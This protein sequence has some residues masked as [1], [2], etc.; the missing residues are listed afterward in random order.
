MSACIY[1]TWIDNIQTE[2]LKSHFAVNEEVDRL[3][4]SEFVE[5]EYIFSPSADFFYLQSLSKKK[6]V[7]YWKRSSLICFKKKAILPSQK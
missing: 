4:F 2:N 6:K 3:F 5:G 7:K 1:S